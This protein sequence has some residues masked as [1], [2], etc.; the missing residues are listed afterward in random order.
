[1]KILEIM[2][3]PE[4]KEMCRER[5]IPRQENGKKL[6]KSELIDRLREYDRTIIQKVVDAPKKKHV[7]EEPEE[8]MAP[9]LFGTLNPSVMHGV[10]KERIT[11]AKDILPKLKALVEKY[12]GKCDD[13]KITAG[14][15]VIYVRYIETRSGKYV[16]KLS[17]AEVVNT[18]RASRIAK[19]K[20]PFGTSDVRN[21]DDFL[22]VRESIEQQYPEDIIDVIKLQRE[23][24]KQ[25]LE[26][27]NGTTA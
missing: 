13:E 18:K 2:T 9:A 20:T 4:L 24:R 19:I 12:E 6:T 26:W 8:E 11:Y 14:V 5:N 10:P 21:Y 17:A 16:Q 23:E 27:R 25:Y 22:F 1:M 3:V 7:T 15:H